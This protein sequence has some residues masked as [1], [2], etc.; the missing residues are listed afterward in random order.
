MPAQV[1]ESH[2][3]A[4]TSSLE[5][6]QGN[7]LKH[8]DML[9]VYTVYI[10]GEK[11]T[12]VLLLCFSGYMWGLWKPTM[13]YCIGDLLSW[14][15]PRGAGAHRQTDL[16]KCLRKDFISKTNRYCICTLPK[17]WTSF[18]NHI[19]QLNHCLRAIN[20]TCLTVCSAYVEMVWDR[21][22]VTAS[23]CLLG[24]CLSQAKRW[25]FNLWSGAK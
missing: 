2:Y 10:T 5:P 16:V 4:S 3:K 12:V 24:W 18:Y 6:S 25:L 23:D 17:T 22:Y 8:V 15:W 14:P 13:V 11:N 1:T 9:T 21:S 19:V 7:F 20:I